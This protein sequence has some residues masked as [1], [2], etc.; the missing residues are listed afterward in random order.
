MSS[1]LFLAL[2]DRD[3]LAY[4]VSS[5]IVEYADAGALQVAAGVDPGRVGRTI[6]AILRELATLRDEVV[7]AEELTKAKAYISGGLELRMEETRYLASWIGGQEALH[8]RVLT[9]DDALEAISSVTV[10]DL[11]R[12]ARSLFR[13]EDLRLAVVAPSRSLRGLDRHLRLPA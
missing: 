9:L 5:G 10:G 7:A 11:S 13:E 1:R 3:A 12:L 4:D 2:V 8:E 6:D